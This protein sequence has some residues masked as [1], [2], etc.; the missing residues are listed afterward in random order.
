MNDFLTKPLMLPELAERM[1]RF[2]KTPTRGG[3]A[4][5]GRQHLQGSA[6][7]LRQ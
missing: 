7:Q 1:T 6:G 3:G 5:A 2:V 4:D